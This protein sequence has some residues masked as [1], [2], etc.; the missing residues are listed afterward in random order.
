[1]FSHIIMRP[2]EAYMTIDYLLKYP[3]HWSF[4]LLTLVS[5]VATKDDDMLSGV[6]SLVPA[7]AF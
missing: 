5:P 6:T 7:M 4:F 2:H 3:V 1:M